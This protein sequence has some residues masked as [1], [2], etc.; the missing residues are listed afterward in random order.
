MRLYHFL[1]KNFRRLSYNGSMFFVMIFLRQW[2]VLEILLFMVSKALKQNSSMWKVTAAAAAG[3][4]AGCAAL[5]LPGKILT[6]PAA[7]WLTVQ[8]GFGSKWKKKMYFAGCLA[9]GAFLCGG[10]WTMCRPYIPGGSWILG[11][12][13]SAAAL[14]GF[15]RFFWRDVL[16]QK[17][18]LYDVSFTWKGRRIRV[19]GFAD[20]GNFLYEPAGRMPVSV[21][22]ASVL[23]KYYEESLEH[24]TEKHDGNGIRMIPYHSVGRKRG[25]MTGIIV[26]DI[27]ISGKDGKIQV[28]KGVIGISEEPLSEK[29]VYQLL[30]HPDLMKYGRL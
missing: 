9:A 24:L 6:L 3:S 17:D 18:F 16:R 28:E 29:G 1:T 21:L 19:C 23:Q 22:E 4:A 8:I 26:D 30:L 25:I 13:I 7:V 27:E 11:G 12:V 5:M 20:T 15:Y 2:A 14:W 10:I